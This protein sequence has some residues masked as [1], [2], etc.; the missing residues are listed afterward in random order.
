MVVGDLQRSVWGMSFHPWDHM[1]LQCAQWDTWPPRR[2]LLGVHLA[3]LEY[4]S[5]PGSRHIEPPHGWTGATWVVVSLHHAGVRLEPKGLARCPRPLPCRYL[6]VPRCAP[7]QCAR[8][9]LPEGSH[10]L[11]TRLASAYGPRMMLGNCAGAEGVCGAHHGR[12]EPIAQRKEG[13]CCLPC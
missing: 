8:R 7:G 6:P 13:C 3:R 2:G 10:Q 5:S 1:Y 12:R 9:G 4:A 11:P